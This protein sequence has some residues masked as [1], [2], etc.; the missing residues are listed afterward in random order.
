[1][2]QRNQV[3]NNDDSSS[4]SDLSF[5]ATEI[6]EQVTETNRLIEEA[7]LDI[8]STEIEGDNNKRD[9]SEETGSDPSSENEN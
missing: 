6:A 4:L 3:K 8:L 1:M 5:L 2:S 9:G 7:S